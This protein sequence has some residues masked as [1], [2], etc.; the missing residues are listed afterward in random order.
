MP[1]QMT[2]DDAARI[3]SANATAGKD[4]SSSSFPATAQSAADK[5][6]NQG[7]GS[8]NAGAQSGANK[9]GKK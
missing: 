9:D 2:K 1:N 4:M 7:G 3:Q 5:N 6:A 8:G